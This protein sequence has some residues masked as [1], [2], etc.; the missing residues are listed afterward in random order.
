MTSRCAPGE[1]P[2]GTW[3][4]CLPFGILLL[5]SNLVVLLWKGSPYGS[6]TL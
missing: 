3:R 2:S 5:P 6:S 1:I 4:R